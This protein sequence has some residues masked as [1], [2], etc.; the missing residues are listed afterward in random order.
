MT[1]AAPARNDQ[2]VRIALM[3]LVGWVIAGG[4]AV[5]AI[6]TYPTWR[7]AGAGGLAAELAAGLIVLGVKLASAWVLT[8]QAGGGPG[9]VAF[10]Y[11]VLV[12]ARVMAVLL[13]A[14]GACRLWGLPP[15]ALL[16]WT[17]AFYLATLATDSIYL[18][19]ALQ[20][21]AFRVAL[22]EIDRRGPQRP[23]GPEE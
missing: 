16:I 12:A 18:A 10:V 6:G 3:A 17:A 1:P 4:V 22:G 20:K 19:R 7:L 23:A 11:V 2:R 8:R 14:V 13:L 9:R 5:A 21:D 15:R